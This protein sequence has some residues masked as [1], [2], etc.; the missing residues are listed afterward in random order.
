MRKATTTTITFLVAATATAAAVM[1]AP[2]S[3]TADDPGPRCATV[4][5][6]L[7]EDPGGA[8]CPADHP[9]CF[10]GAIHGRKL[11]ATTLFYG[12]GSVAAPPASP[13][14]FAYSGV[15]TYTTEDGALVTR[16]TGL[17]TNFPI[18]AAPGRASLSMEVITA[19]TGELAGATG[20]LFV[21]GFVDANRH[22]MSQVTGTVCTP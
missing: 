11:E 2:R 6:T 7:E 17:V 9:N 18:P 15:T 22:V 1:L 10:M 19:G 13:G 12:E 16:E 5:G 8:R 21:N 4:S 14:W 3:A 20:Y